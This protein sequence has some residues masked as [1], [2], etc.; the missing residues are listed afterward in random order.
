[1][2]RTRSPG[3]RWHS[4]GSS[5][6]LSKGEGGGLPQDTES[7][8]QRWVGSI[9]DGK[10]AQYQLR[11]KSEKGRSDVQLWSQI[12]KSKS[13]GEVWPASG[14]GWMLCQRP[15]PVCRAAW[16]PQNTTQFLCQADTLK[17]RKEPGVCEKMITQ[18][19]CKLLAMGSRVTKENTVG[20]IL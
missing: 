17:H 20:R 7:T 19:P 3:E 11:L 10:E 14:R 8:G 9:P 6:S 5:K 2:K 12:R 15:W 4:L 18:R 16:S 1:M 13:I